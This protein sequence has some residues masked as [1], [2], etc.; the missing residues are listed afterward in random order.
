MTGTTNLLELK[1]ALIINGTS[2]VEQVETLQLRL[3]K[4]KR[5]LSFTN[6]IQIL[7]EIVQVAGQEALSILQIFLLAKDVSELTEEQVGCSLIDVPKFVHKVV[8]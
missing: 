1:P 2:G 4:R 6:P 7:N 8:V 3:A 5:R